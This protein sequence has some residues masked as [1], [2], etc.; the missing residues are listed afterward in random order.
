MTEIAVGF[1]F[2]HTLGAD[3]G[4]ERK[5][6]A[7]FAERLGARIDLADKAQHHAIE[8]LLA[9]FRLNEMPMDAM[10]VKFVASLKLAQPLTMD[11]AA[12]TALYCE[13]CYSLVDELVRATPG[14]REC[15]AS[16]VDAGIPVGILTN[17]WSPL[18][19]K[20]IARALGDFPGPILVSAAI[21][22]Y[23]PSADAFRQLESALGVKASGLW[24]VGD[25]PLN[26]VAGARAYGVRTV[27][28]DDEKKPYP[29]DVEPPDAMIDELTE[30]LAVIRGT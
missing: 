23:K 6:F 22:A 13:T 3:N 26:D 7:K 30:L 24:Y 19:E 1:D 10:V 15:I 12:L 16:L 21:E 5:A 11:T 29:P 14:A 17:G 18:Q 20:K 8:Q 9:P 25:N 28:F 27:W 4:L 2:D